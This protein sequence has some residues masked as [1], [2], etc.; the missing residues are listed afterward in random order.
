MTPAPPPARLRAIVLVGALCALIALMSVADMFLPKAWDGVVP[1]NYAT[2]GIHVRAVVGG[3]PAAV[4]GVRAGD[5]LLGIGRRML[6]SPA[7]AATELGRHRA[8][9][10]VP[11]L[12][13]RG[14]QVLELRVVLSPYRL[15]S[16]SYVYY[17]LLG[18]LFFGLGFFVYSRR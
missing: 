14:E 16:A 12:V 15:G 17:A 10:T 18:A 6:K 2:D 9:D 4:A 7:E 11:Y 8:G 13:R 3:G 1:D 5:A